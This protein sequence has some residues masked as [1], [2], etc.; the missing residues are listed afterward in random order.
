MGIRCTLNAWRARHGFPMLL[1]AGDLVV[2]AIVEVAR[3][4]AV[5]PLVAV[6]R[7]L[8]GRGFWNPERPEPD[9]LGMLHHVALGTVAA[10]VPTTATHPAVTVRLSSPP[11][12]DRPMS[13]EAH[14]TDAGLLALAV[15]ARDTGTQAGLLALLVR[16]VLRLVEPRQV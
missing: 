12:L 15:G 9:L 10:Q 4:L 1:L 2:S 11:P 13:L 3:G 7:E 8:R 6:N 5:S 16:T 14:P